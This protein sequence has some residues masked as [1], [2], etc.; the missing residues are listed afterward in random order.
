MKTI[1]ILIIIIIL[2]GLISSIFIAKYAIEKEKV[3]YY[4]TQML[5]F[6]ELSLSQTKLLK[7]YTNTT[8]PDISPCDY[9]ILSYDKDFRKN[10][11]K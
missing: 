5:N 9:W 8:F 11:N 4:R 3:E 1:H 7:L 10:E 2:L 6:C